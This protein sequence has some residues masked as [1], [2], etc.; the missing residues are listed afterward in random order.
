MKYLYVYGKMTI[1]GLSGHPGPALP[2]GRV[3]K[4]CSPLALEGCV[5]LVRFVKFCQELHIRHKGVDL[6]QDIIFHSQIC[7]I[8]PNLNNI[9]PISW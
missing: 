6:F 2:P 5:S 8:I 1:I 4:A 7:I 9:I 3:L